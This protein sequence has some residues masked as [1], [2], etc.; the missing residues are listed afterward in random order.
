MTTIIASHSLS[1]LSGSSPYIL[2]FDNNSTS[3]ILTVNTS[4][5]TIVSIDLNDS[6]ETGV[7]VNSGVSLLLGSIYDRARSSRQIPSIMIPPGMTF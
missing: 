1:Q 4:G 6:P 7:V 5:K 3:T 2:Q